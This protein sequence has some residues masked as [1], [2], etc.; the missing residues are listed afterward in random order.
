MS[1]NDDYSVISLLKANKISLIS[2]TQT[3]DY[4]A[5]YHSIQ[6]LHSLGSLEYIKLCIKLHFVDVWGNENAKLE[7]LAPLGHMVAVYDR[8]ITR[9]NGLDVLIICR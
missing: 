2:H 8:F 1:S 9:E 7:K 6:P 4:V 3:Q 5:L